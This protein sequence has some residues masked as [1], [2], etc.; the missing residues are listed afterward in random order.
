MIP[1]LNPIAMMVLKTTL[2]ADDGWGGCERPLGGGEVEGESAVGTSGEGGGLPKGELD[3]DAG[4]TVGAD[5]GDSSG[6]GEEVSGAGEAG[7]GEVS[8]A[9]EAGGGV[10][11]EACGVGATGEACGGFE[12]DAGAGEVD[13]R[14]SIPTFIPTVQCPGAPQ[15]KYLLPGEESGMTVLPSV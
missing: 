2:A 1:K 3:G 7:D 11:E 12:G 8:G 4:D 9:G 14:V 5:F 13:A 15:M 10:L 6:E